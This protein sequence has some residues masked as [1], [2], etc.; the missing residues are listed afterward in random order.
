[1]NKDQ[2]IALVTG[3]NRGIGKEIAK[4]LAEKGITTLFSARSQKKAED[5][6]SEISDKNII[7][8]KLDV[9]DQNS[10]A[11]VRDWI[12]RE[13]GKL[14]ILI[15]NAGI[16]YDTWHNASNADIENIKE[17]F[18]TNFFAVIETTQI[19]MPMLSKARHARIINM[20]SSAGAL[21]GMGGGTPGYSASKAALN[22]F[23]IKLS[24]EI[25]EKGFS[26]NSVCPGWVRT[27]MGGPNADLS[28]EEGADTAV[29]LAT[30]APES[31][32]GKFMKERK[33]RSW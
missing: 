13:Y 7:P 22:V 6:A 28:V 32:T 1:M 20:S 29:W 33:E 5:A 14:D 3:A 2:K 10:I 4:Q 30:E 24:E 15:N 11:Y 16:N 23:T 25:Q 12:K 17:T 8:L 19:L 21:N 18:D 26:V 27:D 9:N 31:L